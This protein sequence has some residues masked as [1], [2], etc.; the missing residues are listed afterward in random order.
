[1]ITPAEALGLSGAA[2][3]TRVR[4][5]MRHVTDAAL[6][7]IERRLADDVRLNDVTYERDGRLE[8]VRIMLRPLLVMPEQLAYI[9]HVCARITDALK[10]LPLLYFGDPE[11]RRVLRISEKEDIWLREA[12]SPEHAS[13]TPI[14]GRLD[15]V[16]NFSGAGWRES[17]QFMEPNLSGVGGI[18]YGPLAEELVMRDV[19]PTLLAHDPDLQIELPRDQRELFLQLLIDHARALGRP[20]ANLCFIEPKYAAGGANEQPAL[21]RH[22]RGK[23]GGAV[24][25][26]DPRELELRGDE[27]Y[28]EDTRVDVAYRDYETRD[29]IAL[30]EAEHHELLAM[31]AL[32]R[33]NRMVSA[34]GGDFDLKSCWEILTDDAIAAR[35]FT[36]EEQRLFQR[37]VLWTRVVSDRRT[38]LPRGEGDLVEHIRTHR[39]ELVLKPNRGYGGRGIHIGRLTEQAA[40][41]ALLE[42][43]LTAAEDPHLA[44]VVQTATTLPVHEFPTIDE[45][46]R[47]EEEPFYVVMGFAP[48]DGGLGVLCRVSQ[49]QV[50]NVAQRGGLAAV[51][52][53]HAP[54]QLR[55]PLR[56]PSRSHGAE[57]RLRSQIADLRGLETAISLLGWD[58]ET[59]LPEG[60]RAGRG[61]QLATL[62]SLRHR[63]LSADAL[64]DLIEEVD[65]QTQDGSL[66][67]AELAR[68]R[69][70]RR[71]ALALPD[72]LVRAFANARSHTLARWEQARKEDDYAIY[73]PAFLRLLSLVRERAQALQRGDQLYDGLLDEYEPGMT[74]ARLD[75]ILLALRTRLPELAATLAERTRRDP[76]RLPRAHYADA[77]QERF[78]ASLLS[79]MGFDFQRGR[80]D[81]S[82]HPFT[83]MAGEDDIRITLRVVD[84]NPLPAV[85]A[86]LHEGGHALY[87]QGFGAELRGTLLS[88]GPGMG[89]HESQS[90]LWENAVGRSRAFWEHYFPKLREAFPEPLSSLSADA[91]YR[92]VNAVRPGVNRVEADE[93][94]YNLHIA[95]RYELEL[96]L[97]SADLQVEELPIAW[98]D[99]SR[100]LLG[101]SPKGAFDGCLQDVH[102]ALGAFGYF[103]TYSLGNLYAA[104]LMESFREQH[105][106]FDAEL[107]RG[108]MGSLL[109]WLR[110]YIHTLGHRFSAEELIERATGRALDVEPFFRALSAKHSA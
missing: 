32:F 86:A 96:A 106:D 15:A 40:W 108:A 41:E 11:V 92:V 52:V 18:H 65:A 97:L 31:R 91:A 78:C 44:Y 33:Q 85:F 47:V 49:K 68:L 13:L 7:R 42:Q 54:S 93:V 28:L 12:W 87:D 51:L 3:E 60:A 36:A 48:T 57:Q 5:A 94:T 30:A 20:E 101:V 107:G 80:F 23:H 58:E 34:I 105:R 75:P 71:I 50:V 53:S 27:V 37:H 10:R 63:L 38:S 22:L 83:L 79:D 66:L 6:A 16:C 95:L 82:T 8:P 100:R 2:L 4:N 64:G 43:A 89:I 14:Y 62:E 109:A 98:A 9:H 90:R 59:Y 25:H 17:L 69:R 84:H 70:L 103:P 29:L 19:V 56:A 24:V 72:D 77:L 21:M 73:A 99:A 76:D 35:H 81:R 55:A 110:Q 102:W 74:C 46:G 45:N 104:Q 39:E 26:A 61:E 1:M 88:E 67:R